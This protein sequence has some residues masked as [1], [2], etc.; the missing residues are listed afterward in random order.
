VNV[1]YGYQYGVAGAILGATL[2]YLLCAL[3]LQNNPDAPLGLQNG[4]LEA[5]LAE[6]SKQLAGRD[7]HIKLGLSLPCIGGS[8]D[9]R[10]RNEMQNIKQTCGEL[11]TVRPA[12]RMGKFFM[13]RQAA[14]N[15]TDIMSIQDRPRAVFMDKIPMEVYDEFTLGHAVPVVCWTL[16]DMWFGVEKTDNR[17][18]EEIV[19]GM[20]E[21]ARGRTLHGSY[22]VLDSNHL[23]DAVNTLDHLNEKVALVIGSQ[24]PWVEAIL[25]SC[26]VGRVETVEYS[27]ITSAHPKISVMTPDVFAQRFKSG[28]LSNYYDMVV[29]YSSIEHSGLGRYG[30]GFDPWG[31]VVAVAKSWCI[32]KAGGAMFVGV[33]YGYDEIQ[34]NAHRVYGDLRYSYLTANW[35]S[36]HRSSLEIGNWERPSVQHAVFGFKQK[37]NRIW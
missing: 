30:D 8:L 7:E 20:I 11:C 29:T 10:D 12:V 25:L 23:I 6:A 18:T 15:C 17:W 16:D 13:E 2:M 14:V 19:E 26:G 1:R 36:F 27:R 4:E 22:G 21:Q 33:P 5:Q 31:D 9:S 28:E 24:T 3:R 32:I 34:F 35:E 37:G